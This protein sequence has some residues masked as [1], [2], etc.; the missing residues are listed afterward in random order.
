LPVAYARAAR[1]ALAVKCG[2]YAQGCEKRGKSRE[3]RFYRDLAR[4]W[5]ASTIENHGFGDDSA[6]SLGN[7]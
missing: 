2:I 6:V 4:A 5:E 7:P 3:A 1:Q